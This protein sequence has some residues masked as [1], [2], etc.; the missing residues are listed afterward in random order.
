MIQLAKVSVCMVTYKHEKFI[1]NSIKGILMQECDF[2]IELILANDFSP[3]NT[4]E[5]IQNILNTHPRS[6]IINY[7]KQEKNIGMMPN[8]ISALEQCKGKFIA[9]CD[10]DDYWTDRFKLQKQVDFLESNSDYTLHFH[11]AYDVRADSKKLMIL[12]REESEVTSREIIKKKMDIPTLAMVF[13]RYILAEKMNIL[14]NARAGD[15]VLEILCVINGKAYYENEVMGIKN[16]IAT[17]ELAKFEKEGVAAT[18]KKYESNLALLDNLKGSQ[19]KFMYD[20]LFRVGIQIC[21]QDPS[22]ISYLIKSLLLKF[23]LI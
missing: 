4:D 19:R 23:K 12:S 20:Y 18:I 21:K 5:I 8:F 6:S 9:L 16:T 13:P 22:K 10:G 17:G 1:E 7:I 14:K 2:E 3:D 15:R 11:N